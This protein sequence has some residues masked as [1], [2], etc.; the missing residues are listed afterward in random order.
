DMIMTIV[1]W[2]GWAA[3][4]VGIIGAFLSPIDPTYKI[5]RFS[6]RRLNSSREEKIA[7]V[8]PSSVPTDA[9]GLKTASR[10]IF[11]QGETFGSR[12]F[13]KFVFLP[14][15]GLLSVGVVALMVFITQMNTQERIC[16]GGAVAGSQTLENLQV[17][18]KRCL[19]SLP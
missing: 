7:E 11:A 14:V 12:T 17:E 1:S 8:L 5:W 15:V 18:V 4:I 16:L 2:I 13:R 6:R 19:A 10:R 9:E 3:G